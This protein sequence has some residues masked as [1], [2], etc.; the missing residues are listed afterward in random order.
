MNELIIAVLIILMGIA[1]ISL[2]TVGIRV[3]LSDSAEYKRNNDR[4]GSLTDAITGSVRGWHDGHRDYRVA[5]GLAVKTKSGQLIEQ[6]RLSD[7]A[8]DAIIVR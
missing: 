7:E 6:G 5:A 2:V 1:A 8:I 3:M 4:Y